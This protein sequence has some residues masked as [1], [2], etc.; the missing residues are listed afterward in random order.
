MPCNRVLEI[1]YLWIIKMKHKSIKKFTGMSPTTITRWLK[2]FKELVSLN[3]EEKHQQ[4][5][6]KDIIVEIDESVFET[7]K[8]W[9][10]NEEQM[11]LK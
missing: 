3:L 7:R 6:G 10:Y 1:S 11:S 2:T 4:I 8:T 5:G 9:V